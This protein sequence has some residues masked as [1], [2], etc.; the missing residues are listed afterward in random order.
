MIPKPDDRR[1]EVDEADVI[2]LD[3]IRV[4]SN[5]GT[6]ALAQELR[7]GTHGRTDDVVM[8][9]VSSRDDAG[10]RRVDGDGDRLRA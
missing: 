9:S 10:E 5:V 3:D 8:P 2:A 1:A 7:E 6:D 4:G